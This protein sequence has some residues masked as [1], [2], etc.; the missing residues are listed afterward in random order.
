M[1]AERHSDD[2]TERDHKMANSPQAKKRARQNEKRFAVKKASANAFSWAGLAVRASGHSFARWKKQSH[3]VTKMPQ[4]PHFAP[5][6][7]S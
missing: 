6:S 1:H 2:P 7:P 5:P 4:L 3:L